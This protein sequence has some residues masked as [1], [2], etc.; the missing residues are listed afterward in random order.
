ME[1]TFHCPIFSMQVDKGE[2]PSTQDFTNNLGDMFKS[3][4]PPP[5]TMQS[6]LQT[7][8]PISNIPLLDLLE[9]R[10]AL[11]SMRSRSAS[12][13]SGLVAETFIHGN[14]ALH[15]TLMDMCNNMLQDECFELSWQDSLFKMLPKTG[16]FFDVSISRPIAVFKITYKIFA[17]LIQTRIAPLLDANQTHDQVGF[18]PNLGV[19]HAFAT[20]DSIVGKCLEWNEP[21]WIASLDLRKAFDRIEFDSLFAALCHQEVP[22]PCIH[23]LSC[24]YRSQ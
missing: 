7:A 8:A 17:T 6:A 20:L 2:M 3:D 11:R 9:L 13:E 21:L 14:R 5:L 1:A 23:L 4:R 15:E 24:L 22:P 10:K 12:D 18:R 19:D 16:D